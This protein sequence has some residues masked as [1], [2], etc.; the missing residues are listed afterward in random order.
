LAS[1]DRALMQL[2]YPAGGEVG[3]PP[4]DRDVAALRDSMAAF[5]PLLYDELEPHIF[6]SAI[7][8]VI[9]NVRVPQWH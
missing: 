9:P 5:L 1:I 6:D 7:Q 4:E 8:D 2:E 3:F